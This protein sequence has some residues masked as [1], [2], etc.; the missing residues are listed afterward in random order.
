MLLSG[1]VPGE[2][3]SRAEG[4]AAEEGDDDGTAVVVASDPPASVD[5]FAQINF[6]VDSAYAAATAAGQTQ[7]TLS[8]L[9][10][11]GDSGAGTQATPSGAAT[12]AVAADD[13]FRTHPRASA[14]APSSDGEGR[15]SA[16][17]GPELGNVVSDARELSNVAIAREFIDLIST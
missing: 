2:E 6:V 17:T 3:S 11:S 1:R 8:E 5:P 14:A 4:E 10:P 12:P 16:S 15:A 13:S 9:D 7:P